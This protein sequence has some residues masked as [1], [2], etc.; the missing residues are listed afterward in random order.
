MIRYLPKWVSLQELAYQ[1]VETLEQAP[2]QI[3]IPLD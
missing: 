3:Q 2:D 1:H